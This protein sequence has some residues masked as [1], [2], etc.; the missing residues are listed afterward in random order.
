M[1]DQIIS[2]MQEKYNKTKWPYMYVSEICY[3]LGQY[4][5]NELNQMYQNEIITIHPGIRGQLIKLNNYE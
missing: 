2:Y 5:K 3:H 4:P 1:K